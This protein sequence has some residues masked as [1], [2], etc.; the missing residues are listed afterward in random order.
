MKFRR[1][2]KRFVPTIDIDRDFYDI[3]GV[4][5]YAELLGWYKYRVRNEYCLVGQVDGYLVGI[6]NGR[7]MNKDIGISLHTWPS[8]AACG[9]DRT[10]LQPKW[11]TILNTWARKKS[12]S[13]QKARLASAAGWLNMA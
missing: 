12:G 8:I 4:R 1:F 5:L 10:C 6:V 3:V 11:N 7:M 13:L 9:S 2:S